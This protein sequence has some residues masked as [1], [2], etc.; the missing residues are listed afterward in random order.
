MLQHI[1]L[2]KQFGYEKSVVADAKAIAKKVEAAI[3]WLRFRKIVKDLKKD[4]LLKGEYTLNITPKAL[5]IKLWTEWWD[6]YSDEEFNL[7]EFIQDLTPKLV[8]WFCEMFKYAA[9]SEAASRIVEDLL[10]PNG[11]FHDDGVLKTRLGSRF[12]LALTEASPKSALR[13]LMRIMKDWNKEDFLHFTEGRREVVWALEKIAMRGDLFADAARLLLALGEA[14]N[15]DCSNNAS[16]VFAG[17]FSPAYSRGAP[18]EVVPADRFPILKEVFESGSRAKRLL[19]FE[20]CKIGLQ[21]MRMWRRTVGAEYQGLRPE[22]KQWEPETKKY[23][24]LWDVYRQVWQLLFSQLERLPADEREK[25]VVILLEHAP[26]LGQIPTLIDMI[27]DTLG[28]LAKKI[29]V[30]EKQVIATITKVCTI[31]R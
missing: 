29:Y 15:E 11:P 12:F 21:P 30:N 20:A 5:H 28:T 13:C 27:V 17:L 22:P 1:A 19:A 8:E 14:E 18:T 10:G 6:I 3:N 7:E 23:G 16:G 31:F 24:E 2:F 9:E 4:G 25:G 26:E